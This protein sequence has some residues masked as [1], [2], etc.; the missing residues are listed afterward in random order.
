[1]I[2]FYYLRL[3]KKYA[4]VKEQAEIEITLTELTDIFQCTARN[5]NLVLKRMEEAGWIHWTPGRGRGHRSK[6]VF[7]AKSETIALES[8]QALVKKGDIQQAFAYLEEHSALPALKDQFVYWLDSHF[9]Y[10]PEVKNDT[11]MDTLRL[12]YSKRIACLDPALITFVV[13]CHMVQQIFDVLIRMNTKTGKIEGG[14]AHYWTNGNNGKAWTFYLRKGVFFHHGREMTSEDVKYSIERHSCKELGSPFRW[15]FAD[16]ER[17]ETIGSYAIRIH[18]RRPNPLFLHHLSYDRTSI[19][20]QD[21]VTELG[22]AF[23]RMPVGTG[24]F[25]VVQHDDNMLV[26][27]A[28]PRYFD[29][30]AHLDRIEIWY[31]PELMRKASHLQPPNYMM[32]HQCDTAEELPK[33]WQTIQTIGRDCSFF[34]FNLNLPGPQQKLAFRRAVVHGID[35]KLL[36]PSSAPGDVT[37]AKWFYE[38]NREPSD[39]DEQYDPIL[40]KRLLAESGYDGEELLLVHSPHHKWFA[41]NLQ[42]QLGEIGIKVKLNETKWGTSER[43]EIVRSSHFTFNRNVLDHDVELSVIE[44]FLADNCVVRMHL[45]DEL[46]QQTDFI[47]ERLYQE[48]SPV[49]RGTYLNRL[50]QL[51]TDQAYVLFLFHHTQ[52]TVFHPSLRNVSL[53]SL[54]WVRFRD[55]WFEPTMETLQQER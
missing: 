17:I 30:R 32:R 37:F 5:V 7:L 48:G 13:E 40:V 12:P 45:G 16:V 23:R 10:R 8:A 34:T 35:R 36:V 25:R 43:D 39:T 44:L 41:E 50:R 4:E 26:L 1:M 15:L 29:R 9:G 33:D 52:R 38:E 28:F 24:P 46:K 11:L 53:N 18:L 27:E 49:T 54:G 51:V 47:I 21:A 19:V 2:D 3:R 20:P 55:L 42:T 14:L 31:T 22:E 6:I